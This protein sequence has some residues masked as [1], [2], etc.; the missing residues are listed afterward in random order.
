MKVD[1]QLRSWRHNIPAMV[2]GILLTVGGC[3]ASNT[4][5]ST[6][7]LDHIDI[8]DDAVK[9]PKTQLVVCHPIT[10]QEYQFS[11]T[12]SDILLP[13]RPLEENQYWNKVDVRFVADRPI[14]HSL[15]LRLDWRGKSLNLEWPAARA[16]PERPTIDALGP[17]QYIVAATLTS[18]DQSSPQYRVRIEFH[19]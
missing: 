9:L 1:S 12:G 4:V 8:N 17:H 2:A 7:S 15:A 19:C 18:R 5:S 16:E 3:A 14:I 6:E 10:G 13:R 11:W